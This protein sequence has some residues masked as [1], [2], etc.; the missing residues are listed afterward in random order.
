MGSN[1]RTIHFFMSGS[2]GGS[3]G[4]RRAEASRPSDF[5][6]IRVTF[7][8]SDGKLT[9]RPGRGQPRRLPCREAAVLDAGDRWPDS[10]VGHR[11][12]GGS[13][14]SF[15]AGAPL[16]RR[17]LRASL[18]ADRRLHE[19]PGRVSHVPDPCGDRLTEGD[20]PRLLRRPE[21]GVRR[22]GRHRPSPPP[23][24]RRRPHL[25]AAEV[26]QDDGPNTAGN[27]APVVDPGTG[28][29]CLLHSKNPGDV[30]EDTIVRGEASRTVWIVSSSDDGV[31]WSPPREITRDV[32]KPEWTWYAT[33]PGH[34]SP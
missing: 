9:T 25:G 13:H 10:G 5:E 30:N 11:V 22:L 34:G 33:G 19:R 8:S 15:R 27:P 3:M 1:T 31:T 14:A 24:P 28:T 12:E 18:R 21:E 2:C 16:D 17:S 6:A 23:Q 29:I 26:V 7:S 20:R 4:A 32:K